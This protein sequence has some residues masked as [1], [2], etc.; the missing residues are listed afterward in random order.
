[1][2]HLFFA[3]LALC[4]T[5]TALGQASGTTTVDAPGAGFRLPIPDVGWTHQ[6]HRDGNRL[7][8]VVIGPASAGGRIVLDIQ[9]EPVAESGAEAARSHVR[10][11]R[12][13]VTNDTSISRLE[14]M[15]LTVAG[16]EAPGLRVVQSSA[17]TTFNV[18]LV[19]LYANGM[20]YRIQFHAPVAQFDEQWAT[21]ARLLDGF[22][23]IPLDEA[24]RE[25]ARLVELAA[26][27][28]SQVDWAADWDEAARRARADG[29]LVVVAVHA[30]PGFDI[31]NRLNEAVFVSDEVLELM[32][33]RFV[34][35]RWNRGDAA[36]FVDHA[37]FGLGGTTFGVGLLVCTPDG[38]VIRQLFMVEPALVADGLRTVLREHPDHAPPPAAPRGPSS[39][40]VAFLID[41][42][43]LDAARDLLEDAAP[44]PAIGFEQVRHALVRRDGEA[45]LR[46]LAEL[47]AR[48]DVPADAG[49]LRLLEAT[50]C[51]GLGR[52]D[53]AAQALTR[54][55]AARPSDRDAARARFLQGA[56]ALAGGDAASARAAWTAL[57]RDLPEEPAAWVAAAL[58]IG[59]ALQMGLRPN[60]R[61]PTDAQARMAEMPR[62]APHE[63]VIRIAPWLV[64]AGDWLVATQRGDGAWETPGEGSVVHPARNPRAMA[65]QAI[66]TRALFRGARLVDPARAATLRR[67]AN[68]GLRRYLADREVVRDAPFPAPYMDYTC[69]GSSY[70]LFL[71]A[72]VLDPDVVSLDEDL[73]AAAHAEAV[74][75]VADLERIQAPNGG[76]SYYI[77]GEIGGAS[78]GAAMSFTTATVLLALHAALDADLDVQA[79]TL[80][81]GHACLSTL[82]DQHGVFDYM[83]IG[84]G[85]FQATSVS[86]AGA[87]G[88]GP[89]CTLALMRGGRLDG[90]AMA[91]AMSTFVRY[92][93]GFGRESRKALMHAGLAAQGSHYLL[94]D[95]STAADAMRRTDDAALE[96][97]ARGTARDA[98]LRQLGRCRSADGSFVDNPLIGAAAGT[99]LAALTLIDL[100][101]SAMPAPGDP[102]P[103]A[104][105]SPPAAP[106]S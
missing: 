67:S 27:C 52:N 82:R 89:V 62:P 70:G 43:Q 42:G 13:A 86:P 54:C 55:L 11:L 37:I 33:H 60:L 99:G 65:A 80:D 46:S 64:A 74:H 101:E 38:S 78:P 50:A 44:S 20:R 90:T 6:V 96:P 30:L 8:R 57:A 84:N 97:A 25:R 21:A 34:G 51:L 59:P 1:M 53:A 7:E 85:P 17:G 72:E 3:L 2:R 58:V 93:E 18:H 48:P 75:L 31:G 40:R 24:A 68:R 14:D 61:W 22:E 35:V 77:S 102:D 19:F 39:E 5:A 41:T 56:I 15:A 69:W 73:R 12:A 83:R 79:D 32:K 63:P 23:L 92:L 100:R 88:R 81:R 16:R 29:R 105:S 49:G 4:W 47:D 104:L 87:A 95:Y 10:A 106:A 103:G 98:I 71:L 36:P 9:V 76:W 45:A 91:P 26:R 28:G 94:Y 66:C